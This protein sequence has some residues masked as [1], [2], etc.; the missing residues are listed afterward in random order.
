VTERRAFSV[1]VYARHAGRVLLIK[2]RRL[3]TWLPVGGEMEPGET[4]IEAAARELREETGLA[5]RFIAEPG[6]DGTPKGYLGYEEH[7]AGSKGMHM[8]FAF[9]AEVDSD[10]VTPNEEFSEFKWVDSFEGVECP[11]NARELGEIALSAGASPESLKA[12]ARRWLAMFNARDL[13]G[14]L[15]LYADDAVHTS[16]KLRA[17]DP[18]TNGEIRGKAALRAW[19]AD[20]YARLPG[21]R[22]DEKALT[23]SDGRVF[24]EYLRVN[25]GEASYVVAEVLELHGGHIVASRVFHG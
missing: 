1:A 12:V 14:L 20:S 2:H 15:A 6:V 19:W 5:G 16:P 25:L 13:E 23:A 7:L 4:P 8:N 10:R 21:L 11:R 17:K 9:V 22:Y 24:M 18:A 3:D